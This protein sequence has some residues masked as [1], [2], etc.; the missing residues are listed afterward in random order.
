MKKLPSP[1]HR[2]K[3][4]ISKIRNPFEVTPNSK[5]LYF[6]LKS[7][8][9]VALANLQYRGLITI[10]GN[11]VCLSENE[12]PEPLVKTFKEDLFCKTEIFRLLVNEFPKVKLSGENGLKARSGLMEYKYD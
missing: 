10:K 5:S 7:L 8:Q 11:T 2:H 1:L 12:L 4:L 6:E 9:K 3:S